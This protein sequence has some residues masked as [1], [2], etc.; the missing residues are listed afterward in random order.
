M[1]GTGSTQSY[2]TTAVKFRYKP[3]NFPKAKQL[4]VAAWDSRA[5]KPTPLFVYFFDSEWLILEVLAA[6]L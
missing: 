3:I 1:C 4:Q 6:H 2:H 5:Q